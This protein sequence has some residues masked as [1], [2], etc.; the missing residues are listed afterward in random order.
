MKLFARLS[1][2]YWAQEIGSQM[3][4]RTDPKTAE[5]V[6]IALLTQAAFEQNRGVRYA[7]I[8]GVPQAVIERIFARPPGK[9]R[10]LDTS[11]C[12]VKTER[13]RVLRSCSV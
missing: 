12:G 4:R 9:Y 6:Q 8:A 11:A 10:A 7:Q 1:S 3:T 5:L 2:F 13:R